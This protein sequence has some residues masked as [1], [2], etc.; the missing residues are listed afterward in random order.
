[1]Q[2][3][4]VTRP[5]AENVKAVGRERLQQIAKMIYKNTEVIADFKGDDRMSDFKIKS[6]DI[7][8]LLKRRPCSVDDIAVGLKIS[9][10]ETLKNIEEL[11]KSGRIEQ[12]RQG[13]RIFYKVVK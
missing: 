11:V 7:V 1:V 4:T 8:E 9:K 12:I 5:P 2:L 6:D 3:N 13:D 10:I